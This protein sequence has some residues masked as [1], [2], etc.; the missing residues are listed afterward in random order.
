[1][2]GRSQGPG[3]AE[4]NACATPFQ[5]TGATYGKASWYAGTTLFAPLRS[6]PFPCMNPK[7]GAQ[8]WSHWTGTPPMSI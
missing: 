7:A 4:R 1:M 2:I 5:H 6:A 8:N 3:Q